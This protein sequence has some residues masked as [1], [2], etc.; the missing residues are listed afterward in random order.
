MHRYS[1]EI[2]ALR[3]VEPT[4]AAGTLAL[5]CLS[6]RSRT[7]IRKP[8]GTTATAEAAGEGSAHAT[9]VR[10]H[11]SAAPAPC[12]LIA[13][14]C[15]LAHQLGEPRSLSVIEGAAW[16]RERAVAVRPDCHPDGELRH[17][18]KP[19][20]LRLFKPAAADFRSEELLN[21]NLPLSGFLLRHGAMVTPGEPCAC[22]RGR[23][24]TA[25]L[26]RR[27]ALAELQKQHPAA[28]FR[29][30]HRYVA[31]GPLV[32]TGGVSAAADGALFA[33]ERIAGRATWPAWST[34]FSRCLS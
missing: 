25:V 18:I 24:R 32:S 10:A 7:L 9:K 30:G 3:G 17:L 33:L 5:R 6:E 11:V 12:D 27:E 4:R 20:K 15:V 31:D 2:R 29:P 13:R 16:E 14:R 22:S 23:T 34:R 19:P 1:R 26:A 28:S 8:I 21:D